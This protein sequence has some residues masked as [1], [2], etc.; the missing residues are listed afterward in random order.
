MIYGD[1]KQREKLCPRVK[2]SIFWSRS[3]YPCARVETNSFKLG[4]ILYATKL[5]YA[6]FKDDVF[7]W[8]EFESK[9]KRSIIDL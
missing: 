8:L 2:R 9:K 7:S 6:S 1:K 4:R 5:Y 3:G